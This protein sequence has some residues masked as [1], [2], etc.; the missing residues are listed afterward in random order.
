[1]CLMA[2]ALGWVCSMVEALCISNHDWFESAEWPDKFSAIPRVGEFV[3]GKMG[4]PSNIYTLRV[5]SIT[6]GQDANGKPY[7]RIALV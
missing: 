4:S 6:H 3:Q 7:I 2:C 1:V 5:C